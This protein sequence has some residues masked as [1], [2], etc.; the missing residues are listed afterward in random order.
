MGQYTI[1]IIDNNSDD[2]VVANEYA[3]FNS[4]SLKWNG[5]DSKDEQVIMGSSLFFTL[6]AHISKYKDAMFSHLFTAGETQYQVRFY[7]T[8]SDTTIWTGFLLPES[9]DEPYTNNTFY[10]QLEATDGLG[11]LKGKY[12]PD[13]FYTE[14]ETSVTEIYSLVFALTGLQ[15]PY[16]IAPAIKNRNRD[17]YDA[18]Y[19]QGTDFLDSGDRMTAYEILERLAGDMLCLVY[20]SDNAWYVEGINHRHRT[21]VNFNRYA[22]DG[23][24][25]GVATKSKLIKKLNPLGQPRVGIVPPYKNVTVSHDRMDQGFPDTIAIEEND[26]WAIGQGANGE[27]LPT[28]WFG[29]SDYYPKAVA[30]DYEVC[31]PVLAGVNFNTPQYISLLRKIYVKRSQRLIFTAVFKSPVS[32]RLSDASIITNGV[33]LT[34]LLNG[35]VLYETI[36]NFESD[37][38]EFK[39]DLFISEQGL[40][41]LRVTRPFFDGTLEDGTFPQYIHIEEMKLENVGFQEKEEFVDTIADD[42]S[43][44]RELDLGFADD[45]SGFSK[46]FRLQKLNE[47][48][49][50]SN[51]I[52]VT[53]LYSRTFLGKNYLVFSLFDANLVA[54]NIDAVYNSGEKVDGLVVHYNLFESEEMAVEAPASITSGTLEVRRFRYA[55]ITED[56]TYWEEWS[57]TIYQVETDRY[58]EAASKIIRRMFLAPYEL[59]EGVSESAFKINDIISF[60]YETPKLWFLTSV[61][62]NV[63]T[64][65]SSVV[66]ARAVYENQDSQL[67]AGNSEPLVNAGEDQSVDFIGIDGVQLE[68]IAFDPDGFIASVSW[69]VVAGSGV[70]LVGADTLKPKVFPQVDG[71]T[72][73]SQ[74]PVTLRVTVMDDDGATASDEVT[75]LEEQSYSISLTDTLNTRD[76]P[77]NGE[78]FGF[79]SSDLGVTPALADDVAITIKGDFNV[80]ILQIPPG[81]AY[82]ITCV[83]VVFKN[84]I[85]IIQNTVS[86]NRSI[87]KIEGDFEFGFFKGDDVRFEIT[88]FAQLNGLVNNQLDFKSQYEIT[89]IEVQ[90]GAGTF[91]GYPVGRE[92]H[93]DYPTWQA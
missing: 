83:F 20:Q 93:Y 69:E 4:I 7:E 87:K 50:E 91:N 2:H 79:T 21:V 24:F 49:T 60:I 65:R 85:Q 35:G 68:A 75:I 51:S 70:F 43:I 39:F 32:A 11:R 82:T 19:V 86:E 26:G 73:L 13:D 34:F 77:I 57:D 28:H 3:E 78:A 81:A 38:L 15:L 46:A 92:A 30:P 48:G 62:W 64:G 17:R 1:D 72:N 33:K 84:G 18:I 88:A 22:V 54:D 37:T 40:L 23:A 71:L 80:E 45:A 61:E 16:Y 89:N 55:D 27:I 53:I 90:N 29:H 36:R 14:K 63:D 58:G 67:G 44:E 31:L 9:Y 47:R 74:L 25:T 42:Y 5:N 8:E 59:F 10:V 6:E 76:N 41:D 12:L 56:R 52:T 66:M